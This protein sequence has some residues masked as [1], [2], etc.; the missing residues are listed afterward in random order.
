MIVV[1]TCPALSADGLSLRPPGRDQT[2]GVK[3]SVTVSLT[4]QQGIPKRLT[5]LHAHTQRE[6]FSQYKTH[7]RTPQHRSRS[8]ISLLQ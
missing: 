7:T 5:H 1:L 3:Q 8:F 6:Q 2:L 4:A